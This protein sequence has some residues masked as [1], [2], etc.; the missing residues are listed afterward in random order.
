MFFSKHY[1]YEM[2]KSLRQLV[3]KCTIE[4]KQLIPPGFSGL[5]QYCRIATNITWCDR[6]E[7]VMVQGYL[8]SYQN[9]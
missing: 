7:N 4:V 1:Q 5:M 3:D 9:G 6:A 8:I 2:S